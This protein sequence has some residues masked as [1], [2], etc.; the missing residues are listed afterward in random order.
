MQTP[1]RTL[2]T[3]TKL[4]THQLLPGE[5]LCSCSLTLR[6]QGH[7]LAAGPLPLDP[8]GYVTVLTVLTIE[9]TI[10]WNVTARNQ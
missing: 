4:G 10:F 8:V 5:A 1:N 3:E 6:Y 2:R 9:N 7:T